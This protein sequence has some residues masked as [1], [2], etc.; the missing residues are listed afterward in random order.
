MNK[1]AEMVITI[2]FHGLL[3]SKDINGVIIIFIM[4]AAENFPKRLWIPFCFH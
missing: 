2:L 3:V 4:D 1:L